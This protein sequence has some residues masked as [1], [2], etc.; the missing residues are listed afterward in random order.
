MANSYARFISFALDDGKGTIFKTFA[1][2]RQW[3]DE[4]DAAFYDVTVR[5]VGIHT[6]V[7]IH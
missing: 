7:T 3:V 2:F 4:T 1:E 6:F 5:K